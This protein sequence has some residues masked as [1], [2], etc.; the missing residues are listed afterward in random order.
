MRTCLNVVMTRYRM[1]LATCVAGA[2][3]G[4]GGYDSEPNPKQA[5]NG[6]SEP[7]IHV[8]VPATSDSSLTPM[9][10]R[11]D[12][13][14]GMAWIPGGEFTMGSDH[15]LGRSDELPLHRVRVDGFWIDRTEVTNKQFREF[16]EATDYVTTA[17]Q[18][19]NWDDLK[20]QLPPGTPKPS[21]AAL[22]PGSMVFSPPR[23][24]VPLDDIRGWWRWVP[25][26]NWRNPVG[27]GS[28]IEG[29][30]DHPVIHVSWDDAVA[31]CRWAGKRLPTEAEWEF[32]ARGA[33]DQQPFVWGDA[34]L[35]ETTP[36][37]NIWQ[38]DFPHRNTRAD[39]LRRD[40]AGRIIRGQF[41]W[42]LRYAG[43]R[44]G[45]V[46]RPLSPRRLLG[47]ARAS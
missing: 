5:G 20:K 21:P 1:T 2:V 27:P 31:Y 42:T 13:P 33:M 14:P 45:M 34:P 24:A 10:P 11:N 19:V 41:L 44:L 25:G 47:D 43:Q 12:A 38:G 4:C 29:L 32:A 16:V 22:Q 40:C 28:S 8:A 26:A 46:C 3:V 39:G 17:E 35:S 36:Q 7:D 37:A 9:E 6:N 15:P 23:S 18:T 30:D